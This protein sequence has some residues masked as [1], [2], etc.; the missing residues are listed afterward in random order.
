MLS[1]LSE[2]SGLPV[3][4]LSVVLRAGRRTAGPWG[5]LGYQFALCLQ[6]FIVAKDTGWLWG[7]AAHPSPT[8]P[9]HPTT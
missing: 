3:M 5:S 8:S 9:L 6:N 1:I 4:A 2:W 7:P